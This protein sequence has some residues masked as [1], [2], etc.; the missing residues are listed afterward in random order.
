MSFR[1]KLS[2]VFNATIGDYDHRRGKMAV[3]GVLGAGV[4]TALVFS[5]PAVPF[6]AV[7]WGASAVG[8]A[9]LA[10]KS[11]DEWKKQRAAKKNSPGL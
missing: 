2:D 9:F 10:T 3:V 8:Q 4:A 11:F 5:T 1:K 7:C 6:A